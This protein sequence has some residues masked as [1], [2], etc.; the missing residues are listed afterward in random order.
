MA[1]HSKKFY[2]CDIS[3]IKLRKKVKH[4]LCHNFCVYWVTWQNIDLFN[5]CNLLITRTPVFW[6]LMWSGWH[7]RIFLYLMH[8]C[9]SDICLSLGPF[10]KL[11][12]GILKTCGNY[13]SSFVLVC[14]IQTVI[15]IWVEGGPSCLP[16]VAQI[17]P[18]SE[19]QKTNTFPIQSHFFCLLE[20]NY[21]YVRR[22]L[23]IKKFLDWEMVQLV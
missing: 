4:V 6:N 16:C 14:V 20:L 10:V 12:G 3:A 7:L 19:V 8:Q 23:N 21:K 22:L 13:C 17:D 11:R 15:W 2:S 9:W 5:F 1:I 18:K